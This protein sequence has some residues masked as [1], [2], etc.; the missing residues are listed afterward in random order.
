MQYK[1]TRQYARDEEKPLAEFCDLNDARIFIERKLFSD[2]MQKLRL[3]YRIF[4]GTK[5]LNEFNR[6]KFDSTIYKPQYASGDRDLPDS[7]LNSFKIIKEIAGTTEKSFAEFSNLNDAKLFIEAKLVADTKLD[8]NLKY[9]IFDNNIFLEEWDQGAIGE[10]KKQTQDIQGKA[11]AVSFRPTP[12]NTSP[13]PPG[14]PPPWVI[15]LDDEKDD[16]K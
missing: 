7:F 11:R 10:I 5:L 2:E 16:E 9:I 8:D 1:T 6:E 12:L 14:S 4:N 3:I 15:D 13:R